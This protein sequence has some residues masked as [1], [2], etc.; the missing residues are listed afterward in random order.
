MPTLRSARLSVSAGASLLDQSPAYKLTHPLLV[1]SIASA[2]AILG[3]ATIASA[4]LSLWSLWTT[5]ALKSI[6][7]VVPV[8]SLILVLRAWRTLGWEADGS[9]WGLALLVATALLVRFRD[10]SL[11]I[12]VLAPQWNLYF[13]PN[14]VVLFLYGIGVVLLFGGRRLVRACIFPLVL[15]LFSNPIPHVFNVWVDLPLQRASAHVARSFAMALGQPL[16]PDNLRLMFTPEF[17]MFIAP[18]CNGIRGAVTMGFIALVAG[19]LYR[20]RWKAHAAV[21][22]AA[23]LLGYLFNFVRLCILVLYYVLAL[24]ITSLQRQGENADYVIGGTLFFLAVFL[25]YTVIQKLGTAPNQVHARAAE[26]QVPSVA[27][28]GFYARAVA[29][30]ILVALGL[31]LLLH[32]FRASSAAPALLAEEHASGSFPQIVGSYTLTRT[33]NETLDTGTLLFHWA[34]YAPTATSGTH[35]SIGLS[36]ILGSHDTLIC[37]SARGEDPLWRGQ[38]TLQTAA[39]PVNFSTAFYNDGATQFI[40]ATTLCNGTSCGEYSTPPAHFGLVWSKPHPQALFNQN[41]ERPIPIL[42]RAETADTTL[43]ADVARRELSSGVASFVAAVDLD[44]LT[45]PYR[46]H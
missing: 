25:L 12:L 30:T 19:Y 27:G 16:T 26:V 35:I 29:M 20:F 9:W 7:M 39:E 41:P 44:R 42:L 28:S 23:I 34:E 40:E 18:G 24:H 31:S 11:L 33:W 17:G 43:P 2:L 3:L 38:Q 8:V 6:G 37:H 21:V 13:P 14:S 22:V 45:L 36:P 5:D 4:V 46:R 15:L 1:P 32:A 10:Q